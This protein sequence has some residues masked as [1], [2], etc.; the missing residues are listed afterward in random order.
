MSNTATLPQHSH[1]LC[2]CACFLSF[3]FPPDAKWGFEPPACPTKTIKQLGRKGHSLVRIAMLAQEPGTAPHTTPPPQNTL[4]ALMLALCHLCSYLCIC[5]GN[6]GA[7]DTSLRE[8]CDMGCLVC[9]LI[10]NPSI[11]LE[12]ISA[13]GLWLCVIMVVYEA[14]LHLAQPSYKKAYIERYTHK[15]TCIP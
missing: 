7:F 4:S 5:W 8:I 12:T 10:E 6:A 14:K 3:F 1:T 13:W 15:Y 2:G 9:M 11:G